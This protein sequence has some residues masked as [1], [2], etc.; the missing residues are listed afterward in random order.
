MSTYTVNAS[1]LLT[2][3]PITQRPAAVADAGFAAAEFWWPFAVA[4]PP[5]ARSRH[6]S[7]LCA[8]RASSCPV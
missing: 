2:E 8:T 6:S 7:A 4:V 5:T 3:L 1:I